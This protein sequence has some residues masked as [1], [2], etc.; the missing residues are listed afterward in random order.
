MLTTGKRYFQTAIQTIEKVME[1]QA[2]AL[3]QAADW[4]AESIAAEGVL[5]V[6]G[7]GHSHAISEDVFWRAGGLAPVNAI[8]DYNYTLIGG[9][10]PT[11]G[12]RLE[13][14]EGYSKIILENYDLRPGENFVVISQSGINP[15]PVEAAMAAKS[16]ELKVIA[17]TSLEQSKNSQ[18]RHS[19]GKRVFEIADLVID[20][21]VIPGDACIEIAP[22][23]P[24]A[25]PLSTVVCCSIMQC[26][27]AEVATRLYQ[28]GIEPPI[29]LSANIPGG[30]DRLAH[31]MTRFGGARLRTN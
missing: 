27:V 1:T 25:A 6:F 18:S 23:L 24:K 12:T 11:R 8:L 16:R 13:R 29:W 9:G 21:C 3:D 20:N 7:A 26:L 19:S 17:I 22:D 28:R 31:L 2:E 14:L 30:D 5:H 10:S 4:I 15:G